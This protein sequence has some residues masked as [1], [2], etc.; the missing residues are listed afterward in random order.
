MKHE[1]TRRTCV[2]LEQDIAAPVR[3]RLIRLFSTDVT[4]TGIG[5]L[6]RIQFAAVKL[7]LSGA[8]GLA[9][10]EHHWSRDVRDLLVSADF[11]HDLKAHE[12]WYRET[13]T[14]L[15]I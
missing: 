9:L 2:L 10:A 13:I 3:E 7:A 1:P 5:D 11:A 14:A 15:V 4:L 8:T 6:E 12:R